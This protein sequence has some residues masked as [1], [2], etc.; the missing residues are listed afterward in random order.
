M[1]LLQI[2]NMSPELVDIYPSYTWTGLSVAAGAVILSHGVY[3][4]RVARV[5]GSTYFT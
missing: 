3:H 1:P 5:P 4:C 2:A